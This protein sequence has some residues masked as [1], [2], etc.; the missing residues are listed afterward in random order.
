MNGFLRIF[1]A[2]AALCCV[3]CTSSGDKA[4]NTTPESLAGTSWCGECE[5]EATQKKYEATL[6]FY[7][8]VCV[9]DLRDAIGDLFS[10]ATYSYEYTVPNIT[11]YTEEPDAETGE[12]EI[13]FN[14]FVLDKDQATI[15][16]R[17][18][19]TLWLYDTQNNLAA[20]LWKF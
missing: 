7:D 18:V 20:L 10:T 4:D 11:L 9:W 6:T 17:Y 19:Y 8:D 3:S 2:C 13:L 16:G 14:G 5:D 1:L 12:R 15:D